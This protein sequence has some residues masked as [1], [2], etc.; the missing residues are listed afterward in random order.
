M[1]SHQDYRV[2]IQPMGNTSTARVRDL[3][4]KGADT[5]PLWI[6]DTH[7]EDVL[8][9][10]QQAPAIYLLQDLTDLPAFSDP[11][12]P[13]G[14]CHYWREDDVSAT[15]Y[16]YLDRPENGLPALAPAAL[17]MQDLPEKVW[18]KPLGSR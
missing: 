15:V 16:F 3:I 8:N 1:Y 11:K 5:K 13:Q 7:G 17:R 10:T 6:L 4:A 12:H 14:G 2:T 18:D 9:I